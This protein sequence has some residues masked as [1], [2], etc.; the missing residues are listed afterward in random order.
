MYWFSKDVFT[1]KEKHETVIPMP[2]GIHLMKFDLKNATIRRQ[3]YQS[4]YEHAKL[5][6]Q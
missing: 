5:K 6:N 1:K 3:T 4:L 2:V